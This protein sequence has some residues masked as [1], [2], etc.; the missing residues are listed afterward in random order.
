MTVPTPAE[1]GGD[2][3]HCVDQSGA[4]IPVFLPAAWAANPALIPAGCTPGAAPGQQFPGNVIPT[5]CFSPLSQ[6]LLPL[7]PAPSFN[8]N[9]FGANITSQIGVLNTRQTS[10]GFSID[11]SLTEKQKLHGSFFRDKYNLPSCCDNGANF[12]NALS[13]EKQEPRLGTGIFLTYSNALS[14]RLVMTAGAGWLGEI[15]NEIN[16]HSFSFP[17]TSSSTVLPRIQFNGP[18]G[19]QPTTWGSGSNGGETFSNNRKLGISFVNNWLY[20]RGRHTFNIDWEVRRGYQED[21][22][23][24]RLAGKF[25]FPNQTE[26][27]PG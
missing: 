16:S 6:T 8:Q 21:F 1:V 22:Q 14:N 5:N 17:G 20:T 3:R 19:G 2:F 10:W 27:N 24:H 25:A 9:G 13:G 23:C 7:I 18:F 11:H 12:A 4:V 26:A 15:N